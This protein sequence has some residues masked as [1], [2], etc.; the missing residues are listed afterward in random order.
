MKIIKTN[1]REIQMKEK[2]NLNLKNLHSK[3]AVVFDRKISTHSP[4]PQKSVKRM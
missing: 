3:I 4:S 1:E 2:I